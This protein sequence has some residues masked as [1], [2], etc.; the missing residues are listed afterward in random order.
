M[1]SN[2]KPYKPLRNPSKAVNLMGY[3]QTRERLPLMLS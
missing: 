2:F 3:Y 1:N